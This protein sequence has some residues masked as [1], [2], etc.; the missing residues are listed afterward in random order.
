MT[1]IAAGLPP[2][3]CA[4]IYPSADVPEWVRQIDTDMAQAEKEI[5]IDGKAAPSAYVFVTN[6]GAIHALD[7]TRFTEVGLSCGFKIPDFDLRF[8]ARSILE[9]V[10]AREKHR[11]LHWLRKTLQ[12]HQS[13]PT[14]WTH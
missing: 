6:F 2:S 10:D 4:G 7:S 1:N 13:I 9:L 8:P 12:T 11:E 3:A 5:T 14:S